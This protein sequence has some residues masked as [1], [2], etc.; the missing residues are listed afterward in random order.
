MIKKL[1]DPDQHGNFWLG[2]THMKGPAIFPHKL[3]V[4]EPKDKHV[5]GDGRY[6]VMLPDGS[7]LED[8]D[9]ER[10]FYGSPQLAL[11]ALNQAM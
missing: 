10:M 11:D 9:G 1:P 2:S 7:F 3:L 4:G 8:L 5:A 6:T